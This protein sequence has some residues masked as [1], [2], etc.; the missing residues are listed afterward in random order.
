MLFIGTKRKSSDYN[1]RI[2]MDK[3]TDSGWENTIKFMDS[4]RKLKTFV[5]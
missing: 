2:V 4:R 5:K 3:I 1:L